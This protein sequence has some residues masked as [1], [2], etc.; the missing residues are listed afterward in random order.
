[1]LMFIM[2]TLTKV[3]IAQLMNLSQLLKSCKI[4]KKGYE[5]TDIKV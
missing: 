2:Y 1:M 3:F 5:T 4:Q